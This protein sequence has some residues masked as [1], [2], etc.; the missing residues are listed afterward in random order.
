MKKQNGVTMIELV[1]VIIIILI[2]TTFSVYT[3]KSTVDQASATEVYTEMN[4]MRDA[5]NGIIIK[6]DLDEDFV[7][8]Q[9]Q[10]YDFKVSTLASNTSEF[11]NAYGIDINEEEFN[12]LYIIVGMDDMANYEISEVKDYYGFDSIKHSY[13]INFENGSVDLLKTIKLANRNVRTFE[14]VRALVDDG[15]I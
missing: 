15:E 3:G 5:V 4:A 7:L 13:L 14:Q 10:N 1:I 12:D 11:E 2:I 6:K 8:T 9:N